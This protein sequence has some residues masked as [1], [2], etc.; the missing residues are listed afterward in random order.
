M[1]VLLDAGAAY[2]AFSTANALGYSQGG[3]LS[4]AG[5]AVLS[6]LA[7]AQCGQRAQSYVAV[8]TL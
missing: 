7:G 1:Q 3:L 5:Q 2:G 6:L 8:H 4:A